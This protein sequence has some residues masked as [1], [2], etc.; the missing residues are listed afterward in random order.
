MNDKRILELSDDALEGVAG[1]SGLT[2]DTFKLQSAVDVPPEALDAYKAARTSGG[3]DIAS[4]VSQ[5][6]EECAMTEPPR[7]TISAP[8][9][10]QVIQGTQEWVKEQ[11]A[12][13][14][15]MCGPN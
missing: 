10:D 6:I 5:A 8:S 15:P 1:G 4:R 12:I 3:G 7:T 9:Y 11:L 13:K 14:P 2:L